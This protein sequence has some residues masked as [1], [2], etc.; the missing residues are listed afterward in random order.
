MT[1]ATLLKKAIDKKGLS[2]T[3]ICFRL[4]KKEIW[5]DRAVLSKVQNGKLPPAKDEVNIVLAEILEIDSTQLRIAAVKAIMP[6]E[7]F[8]LIKA[9]G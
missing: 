4:A 6:D 7:L 1:Y 3:Q 8:K 2:L 9:T 5:L